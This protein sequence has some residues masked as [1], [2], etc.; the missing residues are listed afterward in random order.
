MILEVVGGQ[1]LDS[2]AQELVFNPMGL[3]HTGY[4]RLMATA[5]PKAT[6]L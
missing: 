5:R 4:Q 2:L 1:P 3:D 6:L